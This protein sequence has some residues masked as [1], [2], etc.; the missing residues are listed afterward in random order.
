MASAVEIVLANPVVQEA[1][2]LGWSPRWDITD[3]E[4]QVHID[5]ARDWLADRDSVLGEDE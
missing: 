2:R 5:A 1:M 4:S 3:T